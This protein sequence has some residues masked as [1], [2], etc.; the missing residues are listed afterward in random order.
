M[1]WKRRQLAMIRYKNPI[2]YTIYRYAWTESCISQ[3]GVCQWEEAPCTPLHTSKLSEKFTDIYNKNIIS[4]T[5]ALTILSESSHS[6]FSFSKVF[7]P[8][9]LKSTL[10]IDYILY[11]VLLEQDKH[12]LQWYPIDTLPSNQQHL[13]TA[14]ARLP[15]RKMYRRCFTS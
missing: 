4:A 6:Y 12:L 14:T 2:N 1:W 5:K 15:A 10:P 11:I 9:K 13:Q 8:L 7:N 3:E